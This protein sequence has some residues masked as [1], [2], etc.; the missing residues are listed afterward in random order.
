MN[1]DRGIAKARRRAATTGLAQAVVQFPRPASAPRRGGSEYT[2]MTLLNATANGLTVVA[3]HESYP[4]LCT[5]P[6]C[7]FYANDQSFYC[8]KHG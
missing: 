8:P 7:G 6:G 4:I 2:V 5:V 3:T 1:L